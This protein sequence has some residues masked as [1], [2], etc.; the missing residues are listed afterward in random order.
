[1]KNLTQFL[2][3]Q[4]IKQNFKYIKLIACDIDGVLT[5]N[6]L[7][8]GGDGEVIRNFNVK[9]GLGIKIL[10]KIGIYVC[11]ISGGKGN[12]IIERA[13]DLAIKDVFL[14]IKNKKDIL[15]K[16]KKLYG[17]QTDEIIYVGDDI[18]DLIVKDIVGLFISP[19]DGHPIVKEKSDYV[20]HAKGGDG[21]LREIVDII[22]K[23]NY[24]KDFNHK[25]W[26]D[27]N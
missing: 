10:Q 14:E 13:K 15:N 25:N 24:F 11:F 4:K 20:T 5:N 6:I 18:N 2:K 19:K 8:Y 22:L 3:L 23:N 1:M 7:S 9:D 27:T 16:I 17:L 21:V 12:S 26:L